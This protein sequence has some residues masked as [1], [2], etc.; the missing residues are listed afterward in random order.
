MSVEARAARLA[1]S[2]DVSESTIQSELDRLLARRVPIETAVAAVR[3]IHRTSRPPVE[4]IDSI[5]TD[6]SLVTVCGRIDRCGRRPIRQDSRERV[7]A[8]GRLVDGSGRI[9]FTAWQRF[10]PSVGDRVLVEGAEVRTWHGRPQLNVVD[11]TR[12][13]VV[14]GV[15]RQP[16]ETHLA[17][18]RPGDRGLTIAGQIHD[19]EQCTVEGVDGPQRVRR[20]VIA[21]TTARLPITD[22]SDNDGIESGT[23]ARLGNVYV[24]QYHSVPAVNCSR[25]TTI[26]E[27]PAVEIPRTPRVRSI[28]SLLA[29]GGVI[30]A[31]ANGTII[32]LCAG[33]GVIARCPT[34]GRVV[35]GSRC[36][37]HGAVD[38][39][40]DLRVK[41]VFDD[42]TAAVRLVLDTDITVTIYGA[43]V[44][45]ASEEAQATM[46]NGVVA[47]QIADAIVGRTYRVRG[48]CTVGTHGGRMIAETFDPIA[49]P[50]DDRASDVL[51]GID[52]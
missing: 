50:P 32:E 41:A 51:G 34:C 31:V 47:E 5:T 30:D 36:R 12:V 43:D 25:F 14:G 37:R 18:L 38:P 21:D 4:R 42:G 48:R 27:A 35:D 33:S 24:Q 46:H 44:E 19:I 13:T 3:R 11:G 8:E 39:D 17:E 28:R 29:T 20:G 22:W 16:R 10:G 23:H 49:M 6:R 26:T 9:P 15:D 2:I 7:I 40:P 1:A 45:A 52:R